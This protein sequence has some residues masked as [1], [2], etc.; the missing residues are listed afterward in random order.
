MR[1]GKLKQ[2]EEKILLIKHAEDKKD[3]IIAYIKKN[4]P[5]EVPELLWIKPED[6]NEAYAKRIEA[7][8]Q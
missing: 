4:H 5:Y 6:V 3:K 8:K 1:E 2:E 7:S